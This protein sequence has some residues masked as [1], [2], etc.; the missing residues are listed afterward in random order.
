MKKY[1]ACPVLT[2]TIVTGYSRQTQMSDEEVS[3]APKEYRR[4]EGY[5]PMPHRYKYSLQALQY[6]KE[7]FSEP[8]VA[9]ASKGYQRM[10]E[11]FEQEK[12]NP[13][14]ES[15]NQYEYRAKKIVKSMEIAGL[16]Y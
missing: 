5:V 8:T 14:G 1:L 2:G 7:K 13:T 3:F 16:Q 12:W 9:L 10:M 15:V 4:T 11:V 6:M